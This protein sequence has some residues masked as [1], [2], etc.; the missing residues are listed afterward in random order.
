MGLF[1]KWERK[2]ESAGSTLASSEVVSV[3]Y[4]LVC[5]CPETDVRLWGT[6]S[7]GII[8]GTLYGKIACV[9]FCFVF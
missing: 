7:S 1:L 6:F 5:C 8:N 9:L 3:K 4:L 2:G